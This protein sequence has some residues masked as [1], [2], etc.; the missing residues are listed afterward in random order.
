MPFSCQKFLLQSSTHN[1]YVGKGYYQSNG[2]LAAGAKR[3]KRKVS[4]GWRFPW[5]AAPLWKTPP[6]RFTFPF[7]PHGA[8]EEDSTSNW[9]LST[10]VQSRFYSTSDLDMLPKTFH[11]CGANANCGLI[12]QPIQEWCR[13]GRGIPYNHHHNQG[14]LLTYTHNL[15]HR[16]INLWQDRTCN[17][18]APFCALHGQIMSIVLRRQFLERGIHPLQPCCSLLC[19]T[20]LKILWGRNN[21]M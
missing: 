14:W 15:E 9:G 16:A 8:G 21:N 1:W 3:N 12:T 5:Q 6:C 4:S 7:C 17:F 20:Y 2:N 11:S 13:F 19:F 10:N 18:V